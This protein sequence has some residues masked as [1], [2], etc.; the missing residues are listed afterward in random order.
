[1]TAEDA[2]GNVSAAS[3]E[4]RGDDRRRD[5][6]DGAAR[7]WPRPSGQ[8]G[9]PVLDG[10]D[11]Q[12][13]RRQVQRPPRHDERLH[14][15]AGEPDRAADRHEP[16]GHRLA[17]GTYYYK[18]TAEDAAGNVGRGLEQGERDRRRT[19][20]AADGAAGLRRRAARAR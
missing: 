18:V 17:P 5:R 2:A 10:G 11:R 6:A 7:T 15:G 14:A 19:T 3:N 13:R 8:L 9:Q 1:M 12:R 20:T 4:Q 16:R